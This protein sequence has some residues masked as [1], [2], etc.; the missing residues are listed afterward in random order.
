[1]KIAMFYHSL[2][3]DW[4]HG[5][6]HFLRGVMTELQARGHEVEVFEPRLGWS[7][8]NLFAE[9]GAQP[10]IDFQKAYP[11]LKSTPYDPE[12]LNLDFALR[13]T[14]LVIAHEWNEPDLIA[15]LGQHRSS[16]HGLRRRNYRLLFHDTHH[17]CVTDPAS[18]AR[19]DLTHYD[20][21]LAFGEA[22]RELYLT[23]RW[24]RQVWTWHEAAD[25]RVF[26][27]HYNT[28]PQGDLVWI[29]NWGDEERT[30]ELQEFL[31]EP[32]RELGLRT[33]VYGVRYPQPAIDLL[34]RAKIAYGGWLPNYL[35]PQVFAGY[36]ATVHVPRRPYV[37]ALPGI[38]TIRVFEAMACGIPLVCS[39][40]DDCEQLFTPGEDYLVA[41]DKGEMKSHLR[42]LLHDERLRQTLA[43]H[44]RKTIL[45]RHT[46]AHRVNELLSICET[47]GLRTAAH[48]TPAAAPSLA[49]AAGG[50]R[51]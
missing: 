22:M 31:I 20:G 37:K 39:P 11:G 10:I 21:V 48:P 30:S 3:S 42:L 36:K 41:R 19:F 33:Q 25:V 5:N 4:N 28:A 49:L 43:S 44:A 24:A 26:H 47:L 32:A 8:Q 38:P 2:L 9:R 17:R 29:G 15:R 27:P 18:L 40:W 1:M 12:Q 51:A 23:Y 46:C 34:Q 7:L 35:A 13:D 45:A 16:R 14:D 6:A 50:A